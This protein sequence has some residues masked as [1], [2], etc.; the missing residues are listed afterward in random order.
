MQDKQRGRKDQLQV[1][2]LFDCGNS[3]DNLIEIL[4]QAKFV[5]DNRAYLSQLHGIT[6]NCEIYYKLFSIYK[7]HKIV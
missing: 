5:Q 6:S 4:Q 7:S 1:M 3:L 2:L